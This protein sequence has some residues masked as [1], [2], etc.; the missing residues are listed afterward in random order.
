M[1]E[2][3]TVYRHNFLTVLAKI[4]IHRYL[5][6]SFGFAS[7]PQ[8]RLKGPQFASKWLDADTR[9]WVTFGENDPLR[10]FEALDIMGIDES[11]H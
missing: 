3:Q 1:V 10:D 5:D 7:L 9:S 8:D 11:K 2:C 4:R 6:E